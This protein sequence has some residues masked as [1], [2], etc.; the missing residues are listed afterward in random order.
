MNVKN[1]VIYGLG[2]IL[3]HKF[4]NEMCNSRMRFD[5]VFCIILHHNLRHFIV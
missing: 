3:L 1:K 2:S 5:F 4:S